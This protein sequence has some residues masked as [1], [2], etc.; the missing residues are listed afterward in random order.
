MTLI[1]CSKCK[2]EKESYINNPFTGSVLGEK[3]KEQ[4]CESC[5]IEWETQQTMVINEYQLNTS[6]KEHREV[7]VKKLKEFLNIT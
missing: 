5:F 3:I 4:T 2:V 1:T 6:I 7:L